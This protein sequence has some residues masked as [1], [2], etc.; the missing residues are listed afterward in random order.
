MTTGN[1]RP[2][3][4]QKAG[5]LQ[6][7]ALYPSDQI[8]LFNSIYESSKIPQEKGRVVSVQNASR[9][10]GQLGGSG[11]EGYG[12]VTQ[13]ASPAWAQ[14]LEHRLAGGGQSP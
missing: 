2:S 4:Q 13:V 1:S 6:Q 14:T 10:E 12:L 5:F 9:R 11:G 3:H 7:R 8:T